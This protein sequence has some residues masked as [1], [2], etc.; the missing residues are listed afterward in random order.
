MKMPLQKGDCFVKRFERRRVDTLRTTD[1][2][3]FKSQRPGR[4]EFSTRSLSAT[5]L[6][7]D[8]LYLGLAHQVQFVI[9]TEWAAC[10]QHLKPGQVR[11]GIR[12]IDRANQIIMLGRSIEGSKLQSANG[13][14]NTSRSVA[15]PKC[16]ALGIDKTA[17]AVTGLGSPG[18]AAKYCDRNLR[19]FCRRR[20]VRGNL[21]GK[22]VGRIDHRVYGF[23]AEEIRKTLKATEAADTIANLR[24][25]GRFRPSCK[26][27]NRIETGITAQPCGKRTRLCRAA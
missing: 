24:E 18:R 8:D 27:K 23:F 22:G 21:F 5:I 15:D 25:Y 13:Q 12:R 9:K 6:G 2:H 26:R 17:P 3:N 11:A 19:E 4:V 7:D 16:C 20:G 1:Q 10:Q 14:K